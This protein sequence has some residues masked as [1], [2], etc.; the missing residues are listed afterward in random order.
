ML[1]ARRAYLLQV[2]DNNGWVMRYAAQEAGVH[3]SHIYKLI[4]EAGITLPEWV[5]DSL[6]RR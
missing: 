2:L 6:P 4:S 3:R 1:A 5:R